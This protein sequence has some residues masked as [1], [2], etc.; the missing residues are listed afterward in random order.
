M[1]RP[2]H[3]RFGLFLFLYVQYI[4]LFTYEITIES[5]ERIIYTDKDN[6]CRELPFFCFHLYKRKSMEDINDDISNVL[7]KKWDIGG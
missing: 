3:I 7:G 4:L 6:Y 2:N 1:I 5:E